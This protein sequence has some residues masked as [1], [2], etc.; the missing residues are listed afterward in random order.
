M[1]SRRAFTLIELLV[2][3]AIIAILAA[4]LFPVFAQAKAAAKKTASLSNVKQATLAG[5]LYTGDYDD[6]IVL[7]ISTRSGDDGLAAQYPSA[8]FGTGPGSMCRFG[9]PIL[10]QPYSKNTDMFLCPNDKAVDSTTP[11][12]F[13]KSD[14]LYWYYQG[15]YPSYGMNVTYLNIPKT[16][17]T[18]GSDFDSKSATAFESPANTVFFAEAS[19][20][21]Y[22]L[23]N[24]GVFT[25][26]IGYYRVL[27]PSGGPSAFGGYT[28]SAD[29]TK[30]P[31]TSVRSQGQL[32]GRFDKKTAIVGWL[33]GHVKVTAVD[34]LNPGGT[35]PEERDRFFN[36]LGQ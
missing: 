21:D 27:P 32:Y 4:I 36:G 29:W 22:P 16:H 26:D 2:V 33:D 23:P 20:K 5:T 24:G 28:T 9:Y 7:A 14:S 12:R 11:G 17:P 34:R 3:I 19:A 18:F 6:T 13:N 8:C 25:S 10:L 1:G 31:K 35:T 15:N 30:F